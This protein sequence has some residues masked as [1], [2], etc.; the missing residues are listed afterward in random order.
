MFWIP[1]IDCNDTSEGLDGK[2]NNLEQGEKT[3]WKV[4]AKLCG[5][6][7]LDRLGTIT[8]ENRQEKERE[9]GK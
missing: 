3:L 8:K 2:D 5:T 6:V 4:L 9:V 1:D 7:K